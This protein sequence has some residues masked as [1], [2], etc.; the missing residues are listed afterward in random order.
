MRPIPNRI[1]RRHNAPSMPYHSS[2]TTAMGKKKATKKTQAPV[3]MPSAPKKVDSKQIERWLFEMCDLYTPADAEMNEW[4]QSALD[5]ESARRSAIAAAALARL[6]VEE[7]EVL[8][9]FDSPEAYG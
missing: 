6:S 3:K 4:Y 7:K 8:G 1:G 9:L 5:E 2:M